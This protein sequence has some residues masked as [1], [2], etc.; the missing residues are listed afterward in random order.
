MKYFQSCKKCDCILL[1]G[2]GGLKEIF[3]FEI[4]TSRVL[5][6]G[7]RGPIFF[8]KRF[9]TFSH[10]YRNPRALKS[11]ILCR[12]CGITCERFTVWNS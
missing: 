7:G 4:Y 6:G 10:V 1:G 12:F 2:G 3:G 9:I 5:A 8:A 11:H